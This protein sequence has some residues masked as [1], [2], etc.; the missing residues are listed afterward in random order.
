MNSARR[1]TKGSIQQELVGRRPIEF[2]I[3]NAEGGKKISLEDPDRILLGKE[4][5]QMAVKKKSD[6]V[7][8]VVVYRES[9]DDGFIITAFITSKTKWLNRREQIW[10]K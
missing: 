3:G 4:G 2:G 8:L 1:T 6:A 9:E 10:P 7:S 5:E